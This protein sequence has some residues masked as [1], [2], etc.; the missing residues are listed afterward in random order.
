MSAA[1]SF[2]GILSLAPLLLAIVA[3][4]GWWMDGELDGETV[5]RHHAADL[6]G[7]CPRRAGPTS[8]LAIG[9]RNA[10][11]LCDNCGKVQSDKQ[12]ERNG[13]GGAVGNVGGAV[14]GGL[15]GNQIGKGTGKTVATVGGAVAGGFVGNEVQKKV[16]SETAGCLGQAEGRDRAEFRAGSQGRGAGRLGGQGLGQ[17]PGQV[18]TARAAQG[19]VSALRWASI[20]ASTA[21]RSRPAA[22]TGPT[23]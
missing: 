21:P 7:R 17:Y 20:S 2:Y 11:A 22:A 16:T 5:P 13:A 19:A 3:L 12:E 4:L 9:Y 23:E 15:L 14:V 8:G 10:A 6:D 18:L 1:M